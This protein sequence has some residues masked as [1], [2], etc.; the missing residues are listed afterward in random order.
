M[1]VHA[2]FTICAVLH[3]RSPNHRFRY[4]LMTGQKAKALGHNVK[5]T[6]CI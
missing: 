6:S 3:R 4:G 2:H 5:A 1:M